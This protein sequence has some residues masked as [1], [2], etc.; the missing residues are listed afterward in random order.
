MENMKIKILENFYQDIIIQKKLQSI[1]KNIRL[2][3]T[4][5]QGEEIIRQFV[6]QGINDHRCEIIMVVAPQYIDN[7]FKGT[8]RLLAKIS[9]KKVVFVELKQIC[10]LL[11]KGEIK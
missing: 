8:L 2:L 5:K 9:N 10:K 1:K 7:S 3:S 11:K 4:S 6:E